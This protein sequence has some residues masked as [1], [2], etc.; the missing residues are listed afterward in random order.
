MAI[1]M[2]ESWESPV[3]SFINYYKGN[4]LSLEMVLFLLETL[5]EET[6]NNRLILVPEHQAKITTK[7][8][9]E[10]AKVA[11]FLNALNY[12][13]L[14][15]IL[16]VWHNWKPFDTLSSNGDLSRSFWN[17][18]LEIVRNPR[19][20]EEGLEE[21]TYEISV[22]C[23]VDSL[24][25]CAYLR[26]KKAYSELVELQKACFNVLVHQMQPHLEEAFEK[27][28]VA[29]YVNLSMLFVNLVDSVNIEHSTSDAE[30]VRLMEY[31]LKLIALPYLL[32][33]SGS[34]ASKFAN[35]FTSEYSHVKCREAVLTTLTGSNPEGTNPMDLDDEVCYISQKAVYALVDVLSKFSKSLG[36][37]LSGLLLLVSLPPYRQYVYSDTSR[38]QRMNYTEHIDNY[39]YYLADVKKAYEELLSMVGR[40]AVFE[41]VSTNLVNSPTLAYSV[42]RVQ[43]SFELLPPCISITATNNGSARSGVVVC[44]TAS[45]QAAEKVLSKVTELL[46]AHKASIYP[47][48]VH[49]N[50]LLLMAKVDAVSAI[51]ED[52]QDLCERLKYESGY[53]ISMI[54]DRTLKDADNEMMVL[55]LE[56]LATSCSTLN[57]R[58]LM[59]VFSE[60]TSSTL[61]Q[62][63]SIVN[64]VPANTA[65]PSSSISKT[66]RELIVKLLNSIVAFTRNL[67]NRPELEP[68]VGERILP[69]LLSLLRIFYLDE[70]LV[71]VIC[72]CIKH[73]ARVLDL[74]FA[75][76]VAGLAQTISAV[77]QAKMVSTYLYLIEWLHSIFYAAE[78]SG[79]EGQKGCLGSHSNQGSLGN[80]GTTSE[81]EQDDGHEEMLVE[82][83]YGLQA[84]FFLNSDTYLNDLAT[85]N[86]II[87][88]SCKFIFIRRPRC[89]FNFW[90]S[91]LKMSRRNQQVAALAGRHLQTLVSN[92]LRTLQEAC[93]KSTEFYVEDLMTAVLAFVRSS[94]FA[95]PS[96]VGGPNGLSQGGASGDAAAR[97]QYLEVLLANGL[98]CLP[99]EI[100]GNERLRQ[101]FLSGLLKR[102]ASTVH[103]L[104]KLLSKLSMRNRM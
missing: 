45:V 8:K 49:D 39:S 85:I 103:H 100:I 27:R 80:L 76:Y 41:Y 102:T 4:R 66:D 77:A 104:Y 72:R 68:V 20:R 12:K 13:M 18:C 23:I 63:T 24:Q 1:Q 79:A 10:Y 30:V 61:A 81:N 94:H 58:D 26:D 37:T 87:D 25:E 43:S 5:P 14:G 17:D 99:A 75:K 74:Q 7:L 22:D 93:S 32:M 40:N 6:S 50:I 69:V 53:S 60:L 21:E 78:V 16:K 15:K 28:D 92:C 82:D 38:N 64:A 42:L 59:A 90:K 101:S 44:R 36:R 73:N 84:E 33:Y 47:E 3:E 83:F 19:L 34:A 56:S 29:L 67:R 57:E 97:E 95:L 55:M 51:Q 35:P 46:M 54:C 98:N 31:L 9:A 91:L 65:I 88:C 52:V 89:V 11:E 2:C 86:E 62:L 71:E 48:K 70:E 96:A